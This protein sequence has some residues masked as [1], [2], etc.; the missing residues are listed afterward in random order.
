MTEHTG[1]LFHRVPH[2]RSCLSISLP[3]EALHA[4]K[5]PTE[6]TA[7][8]QLVYMVLPWEVA[9]LWQFRN[10]ATSVANNGG[11]PVST[12][13][14]NNGGVPVSTSVANNGG[15]PVSTSVANNGGVPVNTSAANNGGVPVSTSVANNICVSVSTD[16]L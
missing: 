2:H 13:V 1:W 12:S 3:M 7:A 16:V 9:I 5:L 8:A 14:A 6:W 4:I 10:R 11:V 15:V